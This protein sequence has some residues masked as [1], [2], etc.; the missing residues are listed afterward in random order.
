MSAILRVLLKEDIL[1][2][3]LPSGIPQTVE[4]LNQIVKET[5][6][7]EEDF[8][9]EYQDQDFGGEFFTVKDNKDI[10]DKCT[11]RVVFAQTFI[12][13]YV[14]LQTSSEIGEEANVS[15]SESDT[16]ILSSPDRSSSLSSTSVATSA[17]SDYTTLFQRAPAPPFVLC[18]GQLYLT[19]LNS[20]LTL[21]S[22]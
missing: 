16:V 13:S 2:L 11:I 22:F 7:I 6:A 12:T 21:R 3:Q 17:S 1:K 9:I 8:K 4:E 18:L 5:Y 15:M 10:T 20:P 14:T 19:Y